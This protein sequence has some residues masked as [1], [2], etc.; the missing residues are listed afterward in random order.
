[1]KHPNV[2]Y[3]FLLCLSII[4]CYQFYAKSL[5]EL[6]CQYG[7][8]K[9]SKVHNYTGIYDKYFTSLRNLPVKFLEIGVAGLSSA[10]MWDSYFEHDKTELYFIDIETEYVNNCLEAVI[11]HKLTSR[12]RAFI[13][14]QASNDQL[15]E[16]CSKVKEQFDVII[17]DGGHTMEQQI[18][19]FCF[20]FPHVACGG[21]YII[22]DLHT[23]FW[24]K[25]GGGGEIN[26]PVAG[27][28]TTLFFLKNLVEDVNYVGGVT[29]LGDVAKCDDKKLKNYYQRHIKS[30]H[31][32]NSL[33]FIFKY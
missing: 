33:C 23:S 18:T 32:Y 10:K 25:Y 9:S 3:A 13:V 17:D 6:A 4:F 26:D 2:F 22:E 14:D 21:V 27:E 16:F 15:A 8:D 5:D 1:M 29:G 12:V 30:I 11:N 24:T 7:T 28:G 20:L 31:F 19:S